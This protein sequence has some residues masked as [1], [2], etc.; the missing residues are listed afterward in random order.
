[1]FRR[2]V[3]LIDQQ[4]S[5]SMVVTTRKPYARS[6]AQPIVVYKEG[7]DALELSYAQA[8][9]LRKALGKACHDI[10]QRGMVPKKGIEYKGYIVDIIDSECMY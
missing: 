2:I 4:A 8:K 7:E 1:M 5:H 10:E 9:A 3:Y 6:S